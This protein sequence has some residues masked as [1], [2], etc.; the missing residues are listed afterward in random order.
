MDAD[1]VTTEALTL[2]CRINGTNSVVTIKPASDRNRAVLAIS[3][4]ILTM[5]WECYPCRVTS[6][7]SGNP[8]T[9]EKYQNKKAKTVVGIGHMYYLWWIN[10]ISMC[11][12]QYVN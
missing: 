6:S 4:A 2:V 5:I 8:K 3:F 9:L 11:T 7:A 1:D 12:F 10:N